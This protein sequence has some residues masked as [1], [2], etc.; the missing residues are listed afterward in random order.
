M[1][2]PSRSKPKK[3]RAHL[4]PTVELYLAKAEKISSD[5]DQREYVSYAKAATHLELSV[6]TLKVGG[7]ARLPQ[8]SQLWLELHPLVTARPQRTTRAIR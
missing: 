2:T 6:H 5:R 1:S 4:K 7:A 3:K 8:I